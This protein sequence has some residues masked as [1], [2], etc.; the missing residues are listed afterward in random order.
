MILGGS[1]IVSTW[2]M[3]KKSLEG[4]DILIMLVYFVFANCYSRCELLIVPS[5]GD[6]NGDENREMASFN[7]PSSD[8]SF[9]F[10]S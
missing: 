1:M 9:D 8:G 3:F 2:Y 6:L 5:G 4:E 7:G 10:T